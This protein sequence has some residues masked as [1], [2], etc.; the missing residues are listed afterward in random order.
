MSFKG[1]Q[2]AYEVALAN[3]NAAK[4]MVELTAPIDGL[5]TD[6]SVNPG[7]Q[8]PMGV[9]IATIANTGKMRLTIHV[10]LKEIE[11]LKTGKPAEV[12]IDSGEPVKAVIV[13]CSKSADPNTRLFRV[14]LEMGNP[15]GALK[16]GMY[17]RANVIIDE[18]K[19]ILT[20]N[21]QAL[22]SEEGI[23]KLFVIEDNIAHLRTVELGFSDGEKTQVIAGL[24]QGDKIVI[25][26]KSSLRDATPVE[27][28]REDS[29]DVSG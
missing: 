17:A 27:I 28:S 15:G 5:V 3:F 19:N 20:V 1:A 23:Y 16:P 4:A 18:L 22:F 26:G 2:T 13:E 6:I 14:E 7:Q 10:G 29:A 12:Y 8:A 11:K 9:P 21:N 24:S 25:V